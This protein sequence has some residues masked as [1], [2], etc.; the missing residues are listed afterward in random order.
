LSFKSLIRL[1][2]LEH[3]CAR[4][5]PDS[6]PRGRRSGAQSRARVEPRPPR[7]TL[8]DDHQLEIEADVPSDRVAGLAL[9]ALL[10]LLLIPPLMGRFLGTQAREPATAPQAAPAE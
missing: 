4:G 7:Q 9:S 2:A 1:Q 6:L 3:G 5:K 10:T 8:I